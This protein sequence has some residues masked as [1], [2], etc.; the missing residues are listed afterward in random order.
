M[1]AKANARKNKIQK[2]KRAKARAK[3]PSRHAPTP[4]STASDDARD[5]SR[6]GEAALEYLEKWRDRDEGDWKFSKNRQSHLLRSWPDPTRLP[7]AAFE[8][9]I[10]YCS[11]MHL[12]AQEKTVKHA[13]KVASDSETEL[14]EL[15]QRVEGDAEQGDA[16]RIVILKI[17]L[18]RALK[19]VASLGEGEHEEA[20]A[21]D[22]G[23]EV[24]ADVDGDES[25]GDA[26]S[27]SR[28]GEE[29]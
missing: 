24:G 27:G 16:E 13:R 19:V 1:P 10:P 17:R 23:M 25:D 20:G 2:R 9:L 28:S 21:E 26:V 6:S 15:Q 22:R 4:G 8:L 5:Q 11:T 12:A 14:K 29:S 3:Q 7:R 18:M